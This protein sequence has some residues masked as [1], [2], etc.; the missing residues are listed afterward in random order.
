MLYRLKKA[1]RVRKYNGG[2]YIVYMDTHADL[3]VDESGAVFLFALTPKAQTSNNSAT[4]FLR[5]LLA[6]DARWF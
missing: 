2:G 4:H 3:T 6:L 1:V 5:H